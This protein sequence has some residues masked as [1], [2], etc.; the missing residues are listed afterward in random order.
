MQ[1]D[2]GLLPQVNLRVRGNAF[3]GGVGD[4]AGIKIENVHVAVPAEELQRIREQRTLAVVEAFREAARSTSDV[5]P[6]VV[7]DSFELV[8]GSGSR[9]APLRDWLWGELLDPRNDRDLLPINLRNARASDRDRS[10]DS[11]LTVAVRERPAPAARTR[12]S[13]D[14]DLTAPTPPKSQ[15]H[16][17][18][19]QQLTA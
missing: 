16:Q 1:P 17:R 15:Q 4:I 13:A 8:S 10:E 12:R 7:L 9:S 18:C 5:A 6:V 14:R 11:R 2:L 19:G 3:L